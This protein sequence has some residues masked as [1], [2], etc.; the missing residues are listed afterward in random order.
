MKIIILG[1]LI[2]T[3]VYGYYY[4]D[5]WDDY[6]K[7][8]DKILSLE[9]ERYEDKQEE[10]RKI[11]K[12]RLNH[13]AEMANKKKFQELREKNLRKQQNS[14]QKTNYVKKEYNPKNF[15]KKPQIKLNDLHILGVKSIKPF[16][17][18]KYIIKATNGTFALPKEK[19]EEAE[20]INFTKELSEWE[21]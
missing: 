17:K 6:N 11:E 18:D 16:K 8:Q 15:K 13:E 14:N 1:I 5:G 9:K 2:T 21:K 12:Q 3:Q 19:L 7:R 4:N 20:K 10:I